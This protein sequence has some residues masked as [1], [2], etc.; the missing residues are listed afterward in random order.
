MRVVTPWLGLKWHSGRGN[1][2]TAGWHMTCDLWHV[3]CDNVTW[4]RFFT[5]TS[6]SSSHCVPLMLH[7]NSQNQHRNLIKFFESIIFSTKYSLWVD[8]SNHNQHCRILSPWNLCPEQSYYWFG[9]EGI[10]DRLLITTCY[11]QFPGLE[12]SRVLVRLRPFSRWYM[13]WG[14]WCLNFIFSAV[15]VTPQVSQGCE[16]Q[17]KIVWIHENI[18]SKTWAA[19]QTET[20]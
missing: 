13:V 18:T 1:G 16:L 2:F 20:C 17:W 4:W 3:T 11:L 19:Q 5:I 14:C 12:W 8:S 9:F 6:L 7:E 15:V 10:C